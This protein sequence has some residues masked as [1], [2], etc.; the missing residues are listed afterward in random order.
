M[1]ESK[2]VVSEVLAAAARV[3]WWLAALAAPVAFFALR[4]AGG[5]LQFVVPPL[6]LLLAGLSLADRFRRDHRLAS[7]SREAENKLRGMSWSEFD[8]LLGQLLRERGFGFLAELGARP[9]GADVVA[10]KD[11][12]RHLVHFKHWR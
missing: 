9:E 3:P 7:A 5:W 1:P 10:K 12:K 4:V 11:E 6:L 8:R 2:T